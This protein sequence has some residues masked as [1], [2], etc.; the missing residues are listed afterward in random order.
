MTSEEKKAIIADILEVETS[1]V[2]EGELLDNY[3]TWD[4]V[5]VLSVISVIS[6]NFNRFPHAD[7]IRQFKTV[8]DLMDSLA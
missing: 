2:K 8:Q 1:E 5:A 7:E 6:E 4:S 3:D